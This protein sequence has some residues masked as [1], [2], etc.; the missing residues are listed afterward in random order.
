MDYKEVKPFRESEE[1]EIITKN[2]IN[3]EDFY[4]KIKIIPYFVSEFGLFLI[5]SLIILL[6]F[7]IPQYHSGKL[8]HSKKLNIAFDT[9]DIPKILFHLTDIHVSH[10]N[11]KRK[12]T[13]FIFLTS[14]IEYKPDL[15]LMT[16]DIVDNYEGDRSGSRVG[17]QWREDWEIYNRTVRDL[18]SKYKVI[19]V[20][21]NHDVWALD[22]ATSKD[23]LFLDYSFMFNRENVKTEDDFIIKKV[24]MMN[25]TFILFNDY[26]FPIPH[27]PYGLDVHTSKHQLDLLENMIDSLEE[28]EEC[29]ILSHY[30]VDRVWYIKSSKGN[31]FYDIISNKKVAGLFTGHEHPKKVNINHHGEEGGLEYCTSSPF[32]NKRSGLITIDNGNLIYHDTYIPSPD[33]RPLF[34]MTYPVPN[35][36]V[37]NHHIFNLKNFE[38]RVLSYVTDRNITL[39]V[40]GDL[41][42]ELKYTTTLNNG[43]ILYSLKVD[44]MENGNYN[45][46]VYDENRELCDLSR[47]F[48]IGDSYQGQ[49][50]KAVKNHRAHLVFRLTSIPMLILLFIVIF[51]YRF[52][53]CIELIENIE[54]Y[55]EGKKHKYINTYLLYLYLIVFGPFLLRNRFIKLNKFCRYSIFV[56]SLY[57]IFLPIHFF[58]R[59]NG[60][61][62][63]AFNVFIVIGSS[64]K[65]EHWAMQMSY[66][67]YL[68]IIIPNVFYLTCI[69]DNLKNGKDFKIIFYFNLVFSYLALI[70]ALVINFT[71]MAQSLSLGYLFISPYIITIII[72]KII[73][74]KFAH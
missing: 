9:N 72:S 48:I 28:G 1:N 43:A 71:S 70:L 39:K 21:G 68:S 64:I 59:I 23:N 20:A 42:G 61:I 74:H 36:Q 52:N 46:H 38:I 26:R 7:L 11:P 5:I 4:S 56:L 73:V 18:V 33:K 60:K 24:K 44:N 37:S 27:P 58:N 53:K 32:D 10:N 41:N 45:I 8:F 19:D 2:Q 65:Y 17:S 13:S 25:L 63:F 35:E 30:N 12:N 50:E 15:I 49:R 40:E 66:I 51:P 47:N 55:I 22:S 62:G 69:N 31:D 67:Y 29:Y 57:P 3:E 54:N 16:G 34:F 14:F 6:F